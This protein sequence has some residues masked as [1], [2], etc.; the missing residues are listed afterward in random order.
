MEHFFLEFK[1]APTLR[2]TPESNYRGN[3]NG[4]NIQ[5]IG[6]IQ[7]NRWGDISPRVSAPLLP[8]PVLELFFMKPIFSVFQ[9]AIKFDC[10]VSVCDF[11]KFY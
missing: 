6:G 7:S 5:T 9:Q 11:L 1:L 10:L 8:L 4:D 3:A 2:R